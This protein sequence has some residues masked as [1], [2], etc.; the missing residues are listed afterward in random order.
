[1]IIRQPNSWQICKFKDV[2]EQISN[3]ISLSQ[4]ME[5]RGIPVT[6]IETIACEQINFNKIGFIEGMPVESQEKYLLKKG[7]VLFSHINSSKHLGKTAV[8]SFEDKKLY[9]GTNLLRIRIKSELVNPFFFNYFCRHMRYKG[10]FCLIA[11][12]AVNQASLNQKKILE[13]P[14]FLPPR[15]EQ[16]AIVNKIDM[17]FARVESCRAHLDR[18]AAAIKRFRQSALSLAIS[19][20][21]FIGENAGEIWNP[22]YLKDVADIQLGKMLDKAKNR[23]KEVDYLRNVNVRWFSFDLGDVKKMRLP[24]SEL[25]NFS[26]KNG[27]VFI[28]EGG[29]PGRA[30]VWRNGENHFAYQKALHRV[31]L[32]DKIL[33]EWLVFCLKVDAEKSSL[34]E[35]F[36]GTTIKHL[37]GVALKRYRFLA[38]S[39]K[40]QRLIVE[41]IEKLMKFADELEE[42]INVGRERVESLTSSILAKAFRGEL[43]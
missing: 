35:Y 40:A 7:D 28:C 38:P 18:A 32:S 10:V 3:G 6:R 2:I 5:M 39:I 21:L 27:D 11:Q 4:N 24:E 9:H 15:L 29:E 31:R 13:L 41:K 22:F 26:V 14:F 34:D 12:H 30:A 23:G 43:V 8:F 17:L 37:T 42:K 19:T 1:M 36:T 33:P 16:D 20:P 25:E